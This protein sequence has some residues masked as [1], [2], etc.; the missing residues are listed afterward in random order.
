[1]LTIW[2]PGSRVWSLRSGYR[3]YPPSLR[4]RERVLTGVMRGAPVAEAGA[5][6][7]FRVVVQN[8]KCQNFECSDLRVSGFRVRGL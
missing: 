7:S 4:C 2:G 1:V 6:A 8:S 5:P 3:V